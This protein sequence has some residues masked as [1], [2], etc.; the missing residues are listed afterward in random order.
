M[1]VNDCLVHTASKEGVLLLDFQAA[2]GEPGGRRRREFTQPDG[3][4]VTEAGY[5]V[6]TSYALPI[7][8]AHLEST[9]R[10]SRESRN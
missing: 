8:E 3:S 7:I 9:T 6:L 4:H 5:A 2:L 10:E 1:E